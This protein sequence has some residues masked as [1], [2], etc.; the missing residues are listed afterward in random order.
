VKRAQPGTPVILVTG[1]PGRVA[2]ETLEAHGIDAV[3][4]K[5]VGLHTLRATVATLLE[6]ASGRRR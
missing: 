3:V 4:E 1:W 5:P 6:R 2:P